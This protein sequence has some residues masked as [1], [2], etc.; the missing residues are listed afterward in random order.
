[1]WYFWFSWG[2]AYDRIIFGIKKCNTTTGLGTENVGTVKTLLTAA[3]QQRHH[4]F[5][6]NTLEPSALT[7][8]PHKG[9]AKNESKE[10]KENGWVEGKNE[11]FKQWQPKATL[12]PFLP[13]LVESIPPYLSR[14]F[15]LSS[16]LAT[17]RQSLLF[18]I[19][20]ELQRNTLTNGE[21][22]KQLSKNLYMGTD[23]PN[24]PDLISNHFT[25]KK[26]QSAKDLFFH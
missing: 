22:I 26:L 9:S 23:W 12:S 14:Y 19:T 20:Q 21:E 3:V 16:H 24:S 4:N 8:H 11:Y 6:L 5:K 13:P 1:M 10:R 25:A 18:I 2:E 17:R 15:L 7:Q